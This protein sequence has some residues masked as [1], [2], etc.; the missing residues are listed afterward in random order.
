MATTSNIDETLTSA[1]ANSSSIEIS[2]IEKFPPEILLHIFSFLS[3]DPQQLLTAGRVSRTFRTLSND[4]ILW[5]KFEYLLGST[6]VYR[7]PRVGK[8]FYRIRDAVIAQ[9]S[10]R[11]WEQK[12]LAEIQER[13]KQLAQ[14]PKQIL[15]SQSFTFNEKL[16]FLL[17]SQRTATHSLTT[18]CFLCLLL[19]LFQSSFSISAAYSYAIT[20]FPLLA[21]LLLFVIY[22]VGPKGSKHWID[23]SYRT[24]D[25][26]MTVPAFLAFSGLLMWVLNGDFMYGLNLHIVLLPFYIILILSGVFFYVWSVSFYESRNQKNK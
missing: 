18:S 12:R 7:S 6:T 10:A 11:K 9:V 26:I 4:N 2:C 22:S 8:N 25:S 1:T 3:D 15:K 21:Y 17:Y 5:K 23:I 20:L 24:I 14:G 16:F 19:H 13:R